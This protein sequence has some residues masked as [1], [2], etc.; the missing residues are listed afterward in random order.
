[1]ITANLYCRASSLIYGNSLSILLFKKVLF[2]CMGNS[3]QYNLTDIYKPFEVK[4][5][6]KCRG[7]YYPRTSDVLR[8]KIPDDKVPWLANLPEYKPKTYTSKAV[9]DKPVWADL[10]YTLVDS[11]S[12]QWNKI[13]GKVDRRSFTGK[14]EIVDGVPRNPIGRTGI[15]HRG[16]LGRWGPNHAA[17]PIVTRWKRNEAGTILKHSSSKKPILQFVA[18][19]RLHDDEWAIP[20]G[21]VDPGENVSVT[22]KREFSEEA[23]NILE[24]DEAAV[25]QLEKNIQDL[26]SKGQEVYKGYVDDPRNTDNS[27]METVAVNFHD[28]SGNSAGK[29]DLHAGDDAVGVRWTDISSDL[30]LYASHFDFIKIVALKHIAHW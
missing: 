30:K 12:V 20:G 23:L 25:K 8:F 15:I 5:H 16:T 11:S 4:M 14:Y 13:D 27:W 7:E 6:Y 17:D 9:A 26:F 24:K 10:D 28:D 1:M 21:M 18:I 3:C 19:L 2:S 29:V 22:L